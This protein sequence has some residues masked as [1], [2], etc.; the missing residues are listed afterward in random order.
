MYL[1]FNRR[2]NFKTN[3]LKHYLDKNLAGIYPTS[4]IEKK[5]PGSNNY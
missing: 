1:R 4:C 5:F 2:N 3:I